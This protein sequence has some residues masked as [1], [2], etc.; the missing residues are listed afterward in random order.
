MPCRKKKFLK[1][2]DFELLALRPDFK[3]G[4]IHI[5]AHSQ[6]NH[7]IMPTGK[8]FLGKYLFVLPGKSFSPSQ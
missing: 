5:Y 6:H 4:I 1:T 7:P 8:L 3:S 2:C